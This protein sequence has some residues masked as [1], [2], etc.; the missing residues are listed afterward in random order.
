MDL[1]NYYIGVEQYQDAFEQLLEIVRQDKN[2]QDEAGRKTML[3][4]FTVL[5][6]QNELVRQYRKQLAA[7]L[8]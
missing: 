5:G 3:S 8:N 4:L 1:A 6:N 7:L 2:F